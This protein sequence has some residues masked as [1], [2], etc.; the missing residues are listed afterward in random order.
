MSIV[1]TNN[2]STTLAS[3][4]LY[5]DVSFT[6]ATGTGST[7]PA[8]S[9]GDVAYLTLT[10]G[11]NYEI[12]KVTGRSGDI[13]TCVRG[14]DGTSALPWASGTTV[15]L[16][17]TA[18]AL[19]GMAQKANNL[20]DLTNPGNARSNLGVAIGS[21]VQAWDA[22]LDAIAGLSGTGLLRRTGPATW[23]LDMG[24]G[25][26]TVTSVDIS[27]GLT[28]LTVSGGPVTSS[29]TITL[30]G[31]LVLTSGGTGATTAAGARTN[32]GLGS[33]ATQAA[34]SVSITGGTQSNVTLSNN[35]IGTYLDYTS[36]TPPSYLEGRSWYDTAKH[37]L[38]YYNDS[39]TSI[40]H[41]GQ[42]LQVKVIN[43][44]G[45]TIPNGSPV[46]ITSTTSGQTYPNVAL[47]KADVSATSAVIGLTNGAIANG[48]IGY[49]TANGTCDNVNTSAFSV[50][51][52]LYLSPYSAG[53]L[54]NT[55]PPTG[56]VVQVGVVSYVDTSVGTIYVKQTTP[57]SVSASI[58][59][60]QVAIAN[61]GTGASTASAAR[62]NLG[63]S[64]VGS[65]IFTLTNPS[66]IS[67]LRLNADN[68]VSA[69]DAATF[70]TAIG[71]GTSS[72]TGTVTS[73]AATVPA[74]LSVSGS[75]IT[76]SGTLA[77]GLSGTAL[78]VANGGTGLTSYTAN[79]VLY[80]SA[81]G[82]LATGSALTFDGSILTNASGAIRASGASVP[83][84]GAGLELLYG[85]SGAGIST[86]LSYDRGA[87]AYKPLWVD[88]SYQAYFISG[89][90][91]MR[92]TST[93]L[94]IGTSSP[95]QKLTVTGNAAIS[96]Q[97]TALSFYSNAAGYI[98]G[99]NSEGVVYASA[100][101]VTL[102]TPASG[103]INFQQN[104]TTV[105]KFDSAGNLG[106]GTTSPGSILDVVGSGNPTLTIRGS[107][108]AYTSILKLQAAG[109]GNSIINATGASSDALIFQ[110]TGTERARI[111][112]SGNLL[113]G[114]TGSLLNGGIGILPNGFGTGQSTV[115]IGHIVATPSGTAFSRFVYNNSVIGSITQSGTTN[116]LYNTSSDY[117]LKDIAGPV[118]NSGAFI[119]K[120]NPVQGSWKA[121]G[122]RFIGFLAHELQEAS[123]TVV[124]T[125]V[126]DGEEMQS[127]DYSN[128]ELI[129]NL[130]AEIQS[131]RKRLAALEAK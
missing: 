14:Q 115:D 103:N 3:A 30:G 35:V 65:N 44:T 62:T 79:G 64:T 4:I 114:T 94:G 90:E 53:Q 109:G 43:N 118:T 121:D 17:T 106:I 51:Q 69:L 71:A 56:I 98:L 73:V 96:G 33:L 7:F 9:G 80:A 111:D 123:E 70:R 48:A 81:S 92:L 52:V 25:T 74:F 45:S 87:G 15:Q 86:V 28:G 125:G 37:A 16:R 95:T 124:G 38:A 42:D 34:N 129:A 12:V 11:S 77:I 76:S 29:G 104:S 23:L 88:G 21:N 63:A 75:P 67:F 72:T 10:D 91:Q 22:D 24:A 85:A 108:G 89:S 128:A 39:S 27:G 82:T 99:Q 117:R 93:G 112:S 55:I 26:G 101:D 83:S 18:A 78:P 59:S 40:V 66:A 6:V 8:I 60:G 102:R 84:A 61:G 41:V 100:T 13:F 57:L 5:T 31:T 58:I 105:G 32:L 126:K 2:S 1:F 122:S 49:V 131:L 97:I 130:V 110:I 68:T 46:Y 54:M 116:V 50:G 20:S 107:A 113:V 127:I 47:A 120:L 36:T 19:S 119:D